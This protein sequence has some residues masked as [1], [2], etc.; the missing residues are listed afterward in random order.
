MQESP[1]Q[2]TILFEILE[3]STLF[4]RFAHSAGPCVENIGGCEIDARGTKKG[5]PGGQISLPR[6]SNFAP[7]GVPDGLPEPSGASWAPGRPEEGALGSWKIAWR[8]LG[9][10]FRPSW[11]ILGPFWV[12]LPPPGG[13]RGGSRRAFL[14]AFWGRPGRE[15]KTAHFLNT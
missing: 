2:N 12:D 14:K 5:S 15:A 8:G 1:P 9:T 11:R 10:V 4:N 6:G 3:V 7:R 13:A